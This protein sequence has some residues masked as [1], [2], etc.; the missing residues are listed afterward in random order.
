M[1]KITVLFFIFMAI[2]IKAIAFV[3]EN[4]YSSQEKV[5]FQT[6]SCLVIIFIFFIIVPIGLLL[7]PKFF[8][9]PSD[10]ILD[11]IKNK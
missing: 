4:L 3:G 2:N 5:D 7:Y 11:N 9:N 10:I 1:K 8:K 6:V